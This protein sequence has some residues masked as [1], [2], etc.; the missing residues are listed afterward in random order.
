MRS[1]PSSSAI[2]E[3]AL[4]AIEYPAHFLL[5]N[6]TDAGTS[7]F[8]QR[9]LYIANSLVDQHVGLEETE[10][11]VWSIYFNT[12]LLATLMEFL[13]PSIAADLPTRRSARNSTSASRLSS[14][15]NPA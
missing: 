1:K 3:S 6:V 2:R 8:Q 12:V 15:R 7:R 5:K 14:R 10:D 9:L 11:G 4:P 13:T